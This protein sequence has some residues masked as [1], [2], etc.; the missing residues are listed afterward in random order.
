MVSH[1]SF[2]VGDTWNTVVYD[3][4]ENKPY[5]GSDSQPDITADTGKPRKSLL[6]CSCGEYAQLSPCLPKYGRFAPRPKPA[7]GP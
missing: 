6:F 7:N 2:Y 1:H 4:R 5:T 3:M